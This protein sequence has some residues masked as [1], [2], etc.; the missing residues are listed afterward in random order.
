MIL[1]VSCFIFGLLRR[2][3]TYILSDNDTNSFTV[4]MI[5]MPDQNYFDVLKSQAKVEWGALE[6]I[7]HEDIYYRGIGLC[8]R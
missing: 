4:N 8:W 6:K 3:Q 7:A 2:S 1:C 5:I